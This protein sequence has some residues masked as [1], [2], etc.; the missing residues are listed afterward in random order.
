MEDT[1]KAAYKNLTEEEL[2]TIRVLLEK[3]DF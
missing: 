3:L 1:D 2:K